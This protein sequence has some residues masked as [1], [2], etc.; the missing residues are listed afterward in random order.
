MQNELNL[1]TD[2][3]L[4]VPKSVVTSLQSNRMPASLADKPVDNINDKPNN[5]AI[6]VAKPNESGNANQPIDETEQPEAKIEEGEVKDGEQ[7][8]ASDNKEQ[9]EENIFVKLKDQYQLE[10]EYPETIEGLNILL[11]DIASSPKVKDTIIDEYFDTN[12]EF[13]EFKQHLENGFGLGSY[14]DALNAFDYDGVR[15]SVED[16]DT[17]RAIYVDELNAKGYG[18]DDIEA[19]L[20]LAEAKGEDFL[21][22]KAKGSRTFLKNFQNQNILAKAQK[23]KESKD[24]IERERK[25]EWNKV[26]SKIKSGKILQRDISA[27]DQKALIQYITKPVKGG[28]TQRELDFETMDVDKMLFEDLLRMNGYKIPTKTTKQ[29]NMTANLRDL[30]GKNSQRVSVDMSKSGKDQNQ[31]A[32]KEVSISEMKQIDQQGKTFKRFARQ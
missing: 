9:S 4:D 13:K 5:T 25:D 31:D 18:K 29:D 3:G 30:V 26:E 15:L 19:L 22:E 23:E 27:E 21:Y 10:G 32:K 12:P 1:N 7:K 6:E 20:E 24:R 28:K 8:E 11:S 17:N 16:A 2:I 14:I